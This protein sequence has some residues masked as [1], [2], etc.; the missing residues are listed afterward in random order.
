MEEEKWF[1]WNYDDLSKGASVRDWSVQDW[2]CWRPSWH[3]YSFHS[4]V[5]MQCCQQCSPQCSPASRTPFRLHFCRARSAKIGV[6]ASS[7][8]WILS[9]L[10]PIIY[11]FG[12]GS[13]RISLLLL[14]VTSKMRRIGLP[15]MPASAVLM[16]TTSVCNLFC[17]CFCLV[18]WQSLHNKYQSLNRE[19]WKEKERG[20]ITIKTEK[21]NNLL[22]WGGISVSFSFL[23]VS[24]SCLLLPMFVKIRKCLP[25]CSVERTV[26]RYDWRYCACYGFSCLLPSPFHPLASAMLNVKRSVILID[27]VALVGQKHWLWKGWRWNGG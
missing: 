10:S 1:G 5:F 6:W 2:P 11:W 7:V 15:A 23:V 22:N 14:Q 8:N 16:G 27:T 12:C 13:L 25:T 21:T 19:K 3:A 17:L 4:H 9:R 18:F 24:S 20:K 26:N